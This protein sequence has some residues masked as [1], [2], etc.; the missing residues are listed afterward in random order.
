MTNQNMQQIQRPIIETINLL[1]GSSSNQPKEKPN[2]L[3]I[4]YGWGGSAFANSV[5]ERKYNIS[6]LSKR[7]TRLNQPYMI[8]DL[9]PSFTAPPPKMTIVED[10]AK[11]VDFESKK[12]FGGSSEYPYD[13]LVVAAGAEPNDF[14]I[15][16][17]KAHCLMFKTECDLEILN[18]RLVDV[19]DVTV[20]GAGPTGIELALKLQSLGKT[21]EIIEASSQILPGFSDKMRHAL[22]IHLERKKIKLNLSCKISKIDQTSYS[23]AK[24]TT[25]YKGVL[26]WTCGQKPVEF[27]LSTPG[28]TRPNA[29]LQVNPHVYALGDCIQGHGPPTAQNATQ[30]GHYLAKHF[31]SD[32]TNTHTYKFI[33]K[34]RILHTPEC[35]Y[36]ETAGSLHVLPAFFRFLL[37]SFTDY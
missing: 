7:T 31:N 12:V 13:Y 24:E 30:Q 15:P 21:V 6:V 8:A 10:E 17:V 32:F 33:E 37:K 18:K 27:V 19:T 23:T 22:L 29:F 25:P 34:G 1:S 3:V 11:T 16:G 9:E 14:S 20:I 2:L 28:L 36:L 26:I 5:D 35:I 4:G